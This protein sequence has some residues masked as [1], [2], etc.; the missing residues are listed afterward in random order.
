MEEVLN[1]LKAWLRIASVSANPMAAPQ[2]REAAEF[3][4]QLFQKAGLENV[5]LIEGNGNP[6]VAGDWLHAPGKPTLLC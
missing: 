5:R 3:T 1:D 6:L 2:V 4:A